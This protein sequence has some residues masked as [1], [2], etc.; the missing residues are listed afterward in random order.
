MTRGGVDER[1]SFSQ[2]RSALPD[3]AFASFQAELEEPQEKEG[4]AEV[5]NINFVFNGDEPNRALWS[6]W[7]F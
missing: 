2:R 3:S 1:L 7:M 4:F 5:K 6:R